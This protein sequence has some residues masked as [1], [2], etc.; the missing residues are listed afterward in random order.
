MKKRKKKT[1]K[2][3]IYYAVDEMVEAGIIKEDYE[4]GQTYYT[5]RDEEEIV[6]HTF[7]VIGRLIRPTFEQ[8]EYDL[9][10][11]PGIVYVWL[12]IANAFEV[13]VAEHPD[14]DERVILI[15]L[16]GISLGKPS[17]HGLEKMEVYCG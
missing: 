12:T 9:Q 14:L 3:M 4:N 11:E 8:L 17:Q 1:M 15:D 5:L 10:R 2:R 16:L 6:R 7:E 13:A